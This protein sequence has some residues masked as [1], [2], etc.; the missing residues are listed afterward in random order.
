M[1]T[2]MDKAP[3]DLGTPTLAKSQGQNRRGLPAFAYHL[4]LGAAALPTFAVGICRSVCAQ[5]R[6]A[7]SLP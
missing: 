2:G 6:N 5:R 3:A 7:F 1:S 4:C